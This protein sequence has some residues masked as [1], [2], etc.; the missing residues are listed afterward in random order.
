MLCIE[1]VK[2]VISSSQLRQIEISTKTQLQ[3]NGALLGEGDIPGLRVYSHE[4]RRGCLDNFYHAVPIRNLHPDDRSTGVRMRIADLKLG[5]RS[6]DDPDDLARVEI[7]G[8]EHVARAPVVIR[9]VA[10]GRA[11]NSR[12]GR[13]APDSGW[14]ECQSAGYRKA[15]HKVDVVREGPYAS[16][17]FAHRDHSGALTGIEM[18]GPEFRG[19]T[20]NGLKT[21]S[22][23]GEGKGAFT[24][25]AIFEAPID[26]LSMAAYEQFRRDTIYVAIAGGMGPGTILALNRLLADLATRPAAIVAIAMDNDISGERYAARLAELIEAANLRWERAKPPAD[27]K[28]WN[29]FL[30]IQAGKGDDT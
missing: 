14:T 1:I 29:K 3:E 16:A 25:L 24:R 30:Q 22:R 12:T 26:A 8:A 2:R 18:R 20:T 17:W 23:F 15:T 7:D 6:S 13:A 28:D 5:A 21:L 4:Y 27:A 19:F 11:M 9:G 10:A